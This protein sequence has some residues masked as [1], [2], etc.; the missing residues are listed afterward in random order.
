M[1]LK[2]KD[3]LSMLD[4]GFWRCLMRSSDSRLLLRRL[5]YTRPTSFGRFAVDAKIGEL[6]LDNDFLVGA[7]SKAGML[8][9]KK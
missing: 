4:H 7:L 9:A 2:Q 1:T 8:S 3:K 5:A 6:A